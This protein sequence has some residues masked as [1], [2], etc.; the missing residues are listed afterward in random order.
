MSMVTIIAECR[1]S[2]FA[3]CT[4]LRSNKI[5]KIALDD[6]IDAHMKEI[7]IN[8]KIAKLCFLLIPGR[9]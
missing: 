9:L 6:S 4:C 5:K 1:L 8:L 2:L 3:Y 7:M